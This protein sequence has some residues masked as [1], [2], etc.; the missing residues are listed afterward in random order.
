M[1]KYI[2]IAASKSVILGN[3][4]S[5]YDDLLKGNVVEINENMSEEEIIATLDNALSNKNKLNEMSNNLY[6]KIHEEHNYTKAIENFNNVFSN[7]I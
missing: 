1:H 5:D 7:I 3:I 6:K 2:E 4:P